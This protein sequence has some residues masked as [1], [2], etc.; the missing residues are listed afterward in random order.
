[1]NAKFGLHIL[2]C[3]L[4]CMNSAFA[5]QAVSSPQSILQTSV[6]GMLGQ[7]SIQGFSLSGTTETVAGDSEIPGTF[8][9]TCAAGG[10][11]QLSLQLGNTS[12]AENRSS[13]S[14]IQGGF[15][16]DSDGIQHPF[17]FHN[18]Y[19]P[20]S[21]FCPAI[22]LT[23]ILSESNASIQFIGSEVKNGV[24]VNH[25]TISSVPDSTAFRGDLL[26]H[27]SQVDVFFDPTTSRPIAFDF[28]T[29]P[30]NDALTD[31]AIEIQFSNY[32]NASGVWVPCTVEKYVN[33]TLTL[34][35]QVE[36]ASTM[37]NSSGQ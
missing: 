36:A 33:S 20:S 18:L 34:T 30:D 2:V 8:S 37:S 11:S 31:I 15:W 13:T 28:T 12:S 9:A 19:T 5:Q 4:I 10:N 6:T 35:L 16:I 23:D 32:S 29:H 21:W 7:A 25:Y 27:L 17:A 3:T 24:P 1:M 26:A 22:A 14:G